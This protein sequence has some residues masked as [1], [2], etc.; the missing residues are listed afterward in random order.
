MFDED[1]VRN[2]DDEFNL[3][4]IKR[5]GRIRLVPEIV[6]YYYAR[7]SLKKLWRMYYQYGC[8]KPLVARK[9][10]GVLTIRQVVPF[11]FVLSL[12]VTGV[13]APWFPMM[14]RVLGVIILVYV[15][16]D[17]ACSIIVA[18]KKGFRCGLALTLVFPVLHL[19]YG[20]GYLIGMV[21]FFLFKRRRIGL[22]DK[23]PITR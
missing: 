12:L 14:G 22:V 13:M 3:R 1:L 20:L 19:S 23:T 9:V 21:R 11:T 8:F 17:I 5:G 4:L 2:Q 7:E 6:S 10:G 18:S 16:T 15:V